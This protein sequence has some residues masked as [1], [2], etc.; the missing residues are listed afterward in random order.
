MRDKNHIQNALYWGVHPCTEASCFPSTRP[1]TVRGKLMTPRCSRKF[2]PSERTFCVCIIVLGRKIC[3]LC[4]T[5]HKPQYV[6]F[7]WTNVVPTAVACKLM[8]GASIQPQWPIQMP[9]QH[10]KSQQTWNRRSHHYRNTSVHMLD[11]IFWWEFW[12]HFHN[13]IN[14]FT[15]SIP[16]FPPLPPR[17]VSALCVQRLQPLKHEAS[18]K[19]KHQT[20]QQRCQYQF[21]LWSVIHG[22]TWS[23]LLDVKKTSFSSSQ[24]VES[25]VCFL[26]NVTNHNVKKHHHLCLAQQSSCPCGLYYKYTIIYTSYHHPKPIG[27]QSQT[28]KMPVHF[29]AA[30]VHCFPHVVLS[31]ATSPKYSTNDT[32]I[33]L[34]LISSSCFVLYIVSKAKL[35]NFEKTESTRL[36]LRENSNS[37]HWKQQLTYL[38]GTTSPPP[39]HRLSNDLFKFQDILWLLCKK[40][41]STR[42]KPTNSGTWSFSKPVASPPSCTCTLQRG[43]MGSMNQLEN[44]STSCK[45]DHKQNLDKRI[46]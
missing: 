30:T 44:T 18:G 4:Q 27:V 23:I 32:Q 25:E 43:C 38:F 17:W 15:S 3:Q 46:A 16:N 7:S 1:R 31:V 34:G 21:N 37:F 13:F 26:S 29:N 41:V 11:N 40:R 24:A 33:P 36:I 9:H 12:S 14:W 5:I 8:R 39:E 45:M 35:R 42:P 22:P 19:Q 10:L 28:S 6:M 20:F 2:F